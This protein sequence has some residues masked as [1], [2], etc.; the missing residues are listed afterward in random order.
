[1]TRARQAR[2]RAAWATVFGGVLLLVSPAARAIDEEVQLTQAEHA[3]LSGNTQRGVEILANLYLATRKAAYLHNQ[4]RCYEQSAQY[5]NAIGRY[6]E[7]LRQVKN[8]PPEKRSEIEAH[9]RELEAHVQR[10][11]AYPPAVPPGYGAPTPDAPTYPGYPPP[12][13][14]GPPPGQVATAQP[15]ATTP[16]PARTV[17][18]K[19]KAPERPTS[20]LTWA[21]RITT[22]VGAGALVLGGVSGL[23]MNGAKQSIEEDVEGKREFDGDTY[24]G[25]K[26][27]ATLATV[28]LIAGPAL[29]G[30]GVVMWWLG[31]G[32]D[33]P[34]GA[35]V[36]QVRVRPSIGLT[37]GGL[38]LAIG[39]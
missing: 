20:G 17:E 22:I 39:F 11:Q 27:S 8:L 1:M 14:Q 36:G 12:A 25:G 29:I 31:A 19:A 35:R 23:M 38:D 21:G 33:P 9:V 4:A 34:E 26:R 2:A 10:R 28:G 32:G 30:A 6:H 24:D 5:E 7:F 3:C 18:V 13:P 15:A 37:G 16:P